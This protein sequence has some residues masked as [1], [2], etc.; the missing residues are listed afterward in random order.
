MTWNWQKKGWPQFTYDEK[1]LAAD[2]T[3]FLQRSGVFLGALKYLP[4]EDKTHL[5]IDLIS[6]EALKTSEIEG[7]ILNR[8]SLQSSIRRH[9][10]LTT[11]NREVP[12]GEQGIADM[13]T[14]LN[15]HYDNP[16]TNKQLFA[17]HTMLAHGRQD[18]KQ[19]G[20]YRKHQNAMQVISGPI[21]KPTVHFEAPPSKTMSQEMKRFR[22]W[23]NDSGPEGVRTLPALTR[24]GYAHLYFVSIHPFEDGN[25]R[26]ARAIAEKS[27]SQCLG[28]PTLIALSQTISSDRKTYYQA[29]ELNNRS[30]EITNW[31]SYFANT[32]LDAQLYTQRL[33]DF[34]IEKTRLYDRLRGKLN[35]RQEKVIARLFAAG[36]E[37]FKGGLSAENYLAIT[38]TSRA[39]ATRDL[40][41]LVEMGAVQRTGERK[42]TR[43]TLNIPTVS[44]ST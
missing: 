30:L 4:E 24:A 33:I 32:V 5:T 6:N 15:R 1:A 41:D 10:G 13:M 16:L 26:I 23:F 20:A 42:H 25:G 2:E 3:Q 17:W 19:I 27:L 18:L 29:L 34:L 11:K 7:E 22:A 28:H 14:D 9:F 43:Y 21:G 36:L 12:P 31:L 38:K 39:T 8:D 40:Q 44:G 37:G 35:T